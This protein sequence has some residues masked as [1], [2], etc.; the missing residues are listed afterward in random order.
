M[1]KILI[2]EDEPFVSRMYQ[3]LFTRVKFEVKTAVSGNEG[4]ETAKSFLP[5]VVLLDI[6]IPGIN[7]LEVLKA[8]KKDP[9]T[10]NIA[11]LMV[12]NIGEEQLAGEAAKLGAQCYMVKAD[13]SPSQILEEVNKHLQNRSLVDKL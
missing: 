3:R 6:M 2:V 10:K 5:D 11:V 9:K 13:F 12:T 8:L 1:P 4:L 7:G